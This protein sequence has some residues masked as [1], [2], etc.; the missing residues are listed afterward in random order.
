MVRPRIPRN[1]LAR[2]RNR[3]RNNPTARRLRKLIHTARNRVGHQFT[4]VYYRQNV[5]QLSTAVPNV[6]GAMTFQLSDLPS[7]TDFTDLYDLYK[8]NKVSVTFIPKINVADLGASVQMPTI[9]TVLDSNDATPPATL[10]S[11]MEDE[12]VKTTRGTQLHRRYF[13]PKCQIKLYESIATDGY[14]SVRR[15]PFINTADPT[16][17]HYALK[18]WVDGPIAGGDLKY[19]YC[20]IKIKYYLSLREVQ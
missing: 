18:Y 4:R 13:T 17:P 8:I 2:M 14:A 6:Q 15:N 11:M 12:S 20:D 19:W 3:R 5:L 10:A 16:V 1:R 9:H 7:Y